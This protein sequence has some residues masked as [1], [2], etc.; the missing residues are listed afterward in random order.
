[1]VWG[2]LAAAQGLLSSAAVLIAVRFALGVVPTAE[3]SPRE[4]A[5]S[6]GAAVV[7]TSREG[8]HSFAPEL[9]RPARAIAA[10]IN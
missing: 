2:V 5:V 10:R 9:H 6:L 4:L 1:V 7:L 8:V 3:G